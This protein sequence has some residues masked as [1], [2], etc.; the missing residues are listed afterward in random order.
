MTA[1]EMRKH[2][3]EVLRKQ[4]LTPGPT[5]QQGVQGAVTQG[6]AGPTTQQTPYQQA[7]EAYTPQRY[8][9]WNGGRTNDG[10]KI[11]NANAGTWNQ[12]QQLYNAGDRAGAT[13]LVNELSGKGLF[14][15][16]YDDNGNYNG[17][18]QG[19]TGSANASFQP[20]VGGRLISSG[21]TDTGIW[22]TPDGKALKGTTGGMLTDNGDTWSRFQPNQG[23]NWTWKDVRE[24]NGLDW[25]DTYAIRAAHG[26]FTNPALNTPEGNARKLDT[27]YEKPGGFT[28]EEWAK[29]TSTYDPTYIAEIAAAAG[30]NGQYPSGGTP[31][32]Q[33]PYQ[34]ALDAYRPVSYEEWR[35]QNGGGGTPSAQPMTAPEAYDPNSD[36]LWQQYLAQYGNAQAPEYAGDPYQAQRDAAL[37]AYGEKWQGSEYQPLRDEYLR[38]AAEMEWNY[39]P[40]TDPV[41]QALQKQYRR[42]GQRA[43]EDTLGKYAAMTGGMPSTAAVSAAQQA[44]NYYAAQLSDRLPQVYQDAYNRYLQEYQRQLGISD[45]YAGFD[46]REYQRWLQSQGQN[47]D[48]ADRYNQYGQQD[49]NR[50]QD[51][52][53]QWNRDRSFG[54]GAARDNQQLGRQQVEDQYGRYRDAVGDARYADETA[55]ERYRDTVEDQ[56]WDAQWAQQLREYA[57]SQNW[58]ATEWEQYLREYGD[59]LSQ[60]EREWAYQQL[61]DSISDA[62]YED[63]TAYQRSLDAWEQAQQAAKYGDYSMLQSLGIDTGKA[64]PKEVAYASDGSTYKFNS[65]DAL[66]FTQN[67]PNGTA[68]QPTTMRGGDGSIWRKDEYGGVTIEKNGKIYTY[69][70]GQVPAKQTSAGSGY[71]YTGDVPE[72]Q[73]KDYFAQMKEAGIASLAAA[74]AWLSMNG[75]SK[76]T[77]DSRNAIA[78]A[79]M[80]SLGQGQKYTEDQIAYAREVVSGKYPKAD[81]GVMAWA[82]QV[83]SETQGMK[84]GGGTQ[85]TNH[86]VF[87]QDIVNSMDAMVKRGA[88][89]DEIRAALQDAQRDGD[90]SEAEYKELR[91]KYE[92]LSDNVKNRDADSNVKNS[93]QTHSD[94]RPKSSFYTQAY[95]GADDLF[96]RNTPTK[97]DANGKKVTDVSV[98]KPLIAGWLLDAYDTGKIHKYEITMILD[99]LERRYGVELD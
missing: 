84:F 28:D 32:G 78:E 24:Q 49:Y 91:D 8:T 55:Y 41:W 44:G 2:N 81:P 92:N 29:H 6:A 82:Q 80:E 30:G 62:R 70:A 27:L 75:D 7:L 9:F 11:D 45:A 10:F 22:L 69:S 43:T 57:D 96:Q 13:A 89:W 23:S 1:E 53:D 54:Y 59:K 25:G 19:Y 4:G 90:L 42:E 39:D 26:D 52:L 3:L 34:Q 5:T 79:F 72:K 38:R 94:G 68:D 74:K 86:S 46:D 18:V 56:R 14:S 98:V 47:L 95:Q 76:L 93:G 97:I 31:A 99:E 67:A 15:G 77:N 12:I 36:P 65:D 73:A 40:N 61:R 85:E 88:S 83:M 66:Y 58:K 60:Q 21:D 63:T 48:L 64:D 35:A 20:V 16:Y 87:Y 71:R 51:T 17:F 37:A 50:F 33:T